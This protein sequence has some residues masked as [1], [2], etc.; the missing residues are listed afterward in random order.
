MLTATALVMVLVLLSATGCSH[1]P[2]SSPAPTTERGPDDILQTTARW[3]DNP[4]IDLMSPEGTFVRATVE[5]LVR[6]SYGRGR[7]NEA[8]DDGGYPGF[9]RAFHNAYDPNALGGVGD[10]QATYVGTGYYEVVVL[11]HDADGHYTAGY[12]YFAS[13]TALKEP[14]G[15]YSSNGTGLVA[16][17]ASDWLTFGPDPEI[18]AE[19]QRAPKAHQAGPARIPTDDVFGTWIVT[20]SDDLKKHGELPQCRRLAPGTPPD[21][22][23]GEYVRSTPPPTLPP[24]PGWP[25]GGSA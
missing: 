6:A 1:R 22:P 9:T 21:W 16:N 12:C 20:S 10:H 25:E 4:S 13:M 19:R 5:S 15:R 23:Q 2:P 8:I 18:P 7:G 24:S 11:R 3:L 14:D 17:Y